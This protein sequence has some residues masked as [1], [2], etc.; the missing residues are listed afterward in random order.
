MATKKQVEKTE[1]KEA[2]KKPKKLSLAEFEKKVIELSKQNLTAEKIGLEL[3][4][5]GIHPR[6]YDKK[7]SKILKENNNYVIPDIKN[8]EN[9]LDKVKKHLEK[10]KSDKRTARDKD[11][12]FAQIRKLKKYHN[13]F[14]R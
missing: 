11:R 4:K 14:T 8:L 1:E 5:Q 6:E 13:I 2:T 10:N 12:F 7:I 9:R 3:K